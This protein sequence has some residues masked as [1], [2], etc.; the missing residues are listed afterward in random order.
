MKILPVGA[1]MFHAE[2]WTTYGRTDMMKLIAVYR[3]FANAL[4][5][6]QTEIMPIFEQVRQQCL[7]EVQCSD[8]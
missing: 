6:M 4:V 8:M 5:K 7:R 1:E 2:G 3:H